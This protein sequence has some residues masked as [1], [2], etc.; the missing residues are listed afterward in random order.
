[1]WTHYREGTFRSEDSEAV[2]NICEDMVTKKWAANVEDLMG[3]QHVYYQK[4]SG[5]EGVTKP[6]K[7]DPDGDTPPASPAFPAHGHGCP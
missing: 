2:H 4:S 6:E 7:E 5:R 3:D 1:M